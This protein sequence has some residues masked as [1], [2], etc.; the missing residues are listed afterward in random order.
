MG[1]LTLEG[2]IRLEGWLYWEEHEPVL[3]LDGSVTSGMILNLTKLR[4]LICKVMTTSQS[5]YK[6]NI[7]KKVHSLSV[8]YFHVFPLS[9]RVGIEIV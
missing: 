8:Y 1:A 6:N 5:C 4:F 9:F 3:P 7:G 2:T